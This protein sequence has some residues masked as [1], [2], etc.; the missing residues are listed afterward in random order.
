[1]VRDWPRFYRGRSSW[2]S[3]QNWSIVSHLR[4]VCLKLSSAT[5]E[6]DINC[7]INEQFQRTQ[8]TIYRSCDERLRWDDW[9]HSKFVSGQPGWK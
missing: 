2:N 5:A 6:T 1:M 9:H 4:D 3:E 8:W 7:I